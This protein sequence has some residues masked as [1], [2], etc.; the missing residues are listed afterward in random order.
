MNKVKYKLL[1]RLD[2]SANALR[3]YELI[4]SLKRSDNDVNMFQKH[5]DDLLAQNLIRYQ[6]NPHEINTPLIVTPEGR[7]YIDRFTESCLNSIRSYIALFC[8]F[9]SVVISFF[10][11][12]F[13]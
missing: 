8:S 5:L 1:N 3:S 10:I 9:V 7:D 12:V 13:S 4:N 11:L 2:K 6:D